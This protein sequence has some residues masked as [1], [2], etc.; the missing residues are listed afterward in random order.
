[1]SDIPIRR[2]LLSRRLRAVFDVI[3]FSGIRYNRGL[4]M[5]KELKKEKREQA[6]HSV[7]GPE[8]G[9]CDE[10]LCCC[11]SFLLDQGP[12]F[13][14]QKKT[15]LAALPARAVGRRVFVCLHLKLDPHVH[16]CLAVPVLGQRVRKDPALETVPCDDEE[17]GRGI[18]KMLVM[19]L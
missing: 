1:M 8:L 5:G 17:R 12:V 14:R 10:I 2:Y 19:L 4:Y 16:D 3:M 7:M 11:C 13:L 18:D 6:T 9:P 15:S